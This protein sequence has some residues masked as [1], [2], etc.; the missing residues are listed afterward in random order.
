[1]GQP[2]SE[3]DISQ[4]YLDELEIEV[5]GL[6]ADRVILAAEVTLKSIEHERLEEAYRNSEF[7]PANQNNPV[8]SDYRAA[9]KNHQRALGEFGIKSRLLEERRQLLVSLTIQSEINKSLV[10]I[11]GFVQETRDLNVHSGKLNADMVTMTGQ[12][13]RMTVGLIAMTAVILVA[14]IVGIFKPVNVTI[15]DPDTPSQIDQAPAEKGEN[16]PTVPGP[17]QE[18]QANSMNQE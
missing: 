6:E 13:K 16:F 3:P 4:E 17:T 2:P 9:K 1:M 12:M 11:K 5:A 14:T 18:G 8:W 15:P 7:F 10:S